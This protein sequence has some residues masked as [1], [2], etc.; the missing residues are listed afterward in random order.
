MERLYDSM[1]ERGLS[2]NNEKLALRTFEQKL[3]EHKA[4]PK[5]FMS[6]TNGNHIL[7][8]RSFLPSLHDKTHFKAAYT[9]MLNNQSNHH[10]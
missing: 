6:K 3:L 7:T 8:P 10:L 5:K 4:D 9:I 2:N 1:Q